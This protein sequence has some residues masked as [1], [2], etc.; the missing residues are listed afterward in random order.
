MGTETYAGP[1]AA[2]GRVF[3]GTNNGNPRDPKVEGDQGVLMA[4]SA[5]DGAFLWQRTHAKLAS[6]RINDWP[7]QGV[8]TTPTVEGDHVYYVS[9]RGELQAVEAE[10]GTTVWSLDMIKTLGVFPHHM[11]VSS[12]LVV[13]DQLFVHTSH[14]VGEDG[15]V[16]NADAP[17]FLAV[18]KK[19]GK[20]QWH[21]ASP[22]AK[23]L[24][25]QWSSPSYSDHA[26]TKQVIFPGGDGW[27][28]A[29]NLDGTPR[30][31]FDAN[32]F[33]TLEGASEAPPENL[34][35]PAVVSDGTVF[36]GVGHDPEMGAGQGHLWALDPSGTD[37][38]TESAV[39]WS[40]RDKGLAGTLGAVAVTNGR[41]YLTDLNGFLHCLDAATGELLWKHDTFATVWAPPLVADGKVYVVDEDG[42]VA[43][44]AEG[45]EEKLLAEVNL[46]NSI[47]APPSARDG[48]LYIATRDRLF[49]L[50]ASSDPSPTPPQESSP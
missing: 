42:D 11:S 23:I 33:R 20:V 6:G 30:W 8:C 26:D 22:G 12:P 1:V 40:Y 27:V 36:I 44:L 18:D 14:G 17:S 34:I 46:G 9:S 16:P 15:K 45:T 4:F 19:T 47:Y 31:R 37:D 35:A 13:G 21:D 24:D 50:G 32:S 3:I 38:V 29:F 48:V 10:K 25:G 28:Y 2:G 7:L 49:A 39:R 41:V 5:D 43:I